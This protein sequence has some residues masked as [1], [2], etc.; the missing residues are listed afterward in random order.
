MV[1]GPRGLR[2]RALEYAGRVFSGGCPLSINGPD[3][4]P[5]SGRAGGQL[6]PA[7]MP[8]HTAGL[9]IFFILSASSSSAGGGRGTCNW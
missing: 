8:V 7:G 4:Y 1:S 6:V 9:P 3:G 5:G 2:A